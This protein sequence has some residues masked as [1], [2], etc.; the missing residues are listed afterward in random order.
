MKVPFVC[1]DT[2]QLTWTGLYACNESYNNS[3]S[4]PWWFPRQQVLLNLRAKV[5]HAFA[6]INRRTSP[7]YDLTNSA[8]WMFTQRKW[9]LSLKEMTQLLVAGSCELRRKGLIQT[10]GWFIYRAFY[11][12]TTV[13]YCYAQEAGEFPWDLLLVETNR[14]MACLKATSTAMG[15][16]VLW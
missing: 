15:K 8:G 9:F 13:R 6:S 7:Y 11:I 1:R 2:W 12:S 5:C 10:C 3:T 14:Y 16:E 4:T